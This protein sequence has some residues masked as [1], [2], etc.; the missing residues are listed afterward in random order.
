MLQVTVLLSVL[1]AATV[2]AQPFMI[3]PEMFEPG[4]PEAVQRRDSNYSGFTYNF[5]G[6]MVRRSG[7]LC[8]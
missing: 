2:R 4:L 1:L 3:D 5:T 7:R 6:A 8:T